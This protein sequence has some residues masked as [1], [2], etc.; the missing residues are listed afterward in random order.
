M[1]VKLTDRNSIPWGFG[2]NTKR[3]FQQKAFESVG[4]KMS[5]IFQAWVI[6]VKPC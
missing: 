4:S 1:C 3:L 6:K 2:Q 5:A